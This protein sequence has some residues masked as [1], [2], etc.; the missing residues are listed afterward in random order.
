[1][2]RPSPLKLRV[3][4][5]HDLETLSALL[6][7]ALVSSDNMTFLKRE[8]RFVLVASRFRWESLP[9][10][11]QAR[12][13]ARETA[14]EDAS[15]EEGSAEEDDE[16]LFERSNCGICFDHVIRVHTLGLQ[17][18]AKGRFLELL[19]IR[20]YKG[21]VELIFSG[22]AAIR[23]EVTLLRCHMEDLSE[24]WPTQWCPQHELDD[25]PEGSQR[26]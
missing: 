25:S 16:S 13:K 11:A 24:P 7:D 17:N 2:A 14:T 1:M 20:P 5:S 21:G 19:A 8:K 9:A 12:L 6:Q 22:G 26:G 23:L 18:S 10:D 15:F 3:H 4:D